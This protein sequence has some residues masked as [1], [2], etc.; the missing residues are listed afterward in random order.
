MPLNAFIA[1]V[2]T[3]DPAIE[4]RIHLACGTLAIYMLMWILGDRYLMADSSHVVGESVLHLK[5]AGRLSASIPLTAI[6]RCEPVSA[7]AWCKRRGLALGDAMTATAADRPNIMIAIDPA[8]AVR[9]TSWQV[10]RAAPRY[11]FS[12]VD[13]PSALAAALDKNLVLARCA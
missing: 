12:F 8:A 2:I 13:Q 6:T 10:E 9:L 1:S 11:L 7:G 3:H 4:L 5:I